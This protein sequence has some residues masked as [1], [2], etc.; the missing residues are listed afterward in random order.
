MKND[1][2]TEQGARRLAAKIHEYWK[3]RGKNVR[4][5]ITTGDDKYGRQISVVRSDMVGGMPR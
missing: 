2:M 5:W 3:L 1:N 4:T